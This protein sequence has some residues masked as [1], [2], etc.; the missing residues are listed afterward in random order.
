MGYFLWNLLFCQFWQFLGLVYIFDYVGDD[1]DA[2][3]ENNK[4]SDSPPKESD[5][6]FINFGPDDDVA[7]GTAQ[8]DA[9]FLNGGND[10]ATGGAGDDKIFLAD[11]QDSTA[12]LVAGGGFSTAGMEGN[13]LIRGGAGRDILIDALGSNTIYGDTGYDRMNSIDAEGDANT[14]DTMFG[15]FGN[16]VLFADSGDV[17]SGDTGVDKFQITATDSMNPLTITD[18]EDGE[19]IF[20]R[21][22]DGGFQVI[23]SIKTQLAANGTDTNVMIE[24]QLVVVLQGVT[25]LSDGAIGNPAA[26]PQYGTPPAA[27]GSDDVADI[28]EINAYASKVISYGGDDIISFAAGAETLGRNMIINA[29]DG[30][31]TVTLGEG[32]DSVVGGLGADTIFG[33]GGLDEL[34][35]GFGDDT[36]NSLDIGVVG[37]VDTVFGGAGADTLTGDAGDL[38]NGGTGVDNFNIDMN[39][40]SSENVSIGDFDA[41]TETLAV[42][43]NLGAGVTPTVTYGTEVDASGTT[44]GATVVVNGRVVALLTGVDPDTLDTTNV[45]V[46]NSTT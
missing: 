34:D 29:G 6:N 41:A 30:A 22:K 10:T 32:N 40:A 13:D 44:L 28:I 9:M 23:E 37:G 36:I 25:T 16:D 38:L 18:F 27:D 3:A 4:A 5:F 35:G 26:P 11:G 21:D 2:E 42:T 45:T 19:Q 39:D 7:T 24:N 43:V 17:L 15:G 46:T 31:D 14:T 8:N 33:G 12:T 20:L 1:D